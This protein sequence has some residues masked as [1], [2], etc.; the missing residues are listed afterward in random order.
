MQD[1]RG[2]VGCGAAVYLEA[3][4]LEGICICETCWVVEK[5]GGVFAFI[6]VLG[7]GVEA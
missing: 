3:F 5:V 4:L 2:A 6:Q 7:D 1:L